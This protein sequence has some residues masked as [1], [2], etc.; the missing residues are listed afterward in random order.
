MGVRRRSD[1]PLHA[2]A[3]YFRLLAEPARLRILLCL[4][5]GELNVMEIVGATGMKQAHVS[6]Q[7]GLLSSEGLLARRKEGTRVYYSLV[8]LRLGDLLDAAESTLREHLRG[9]L[10]E[11]EG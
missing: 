9:R 8:D 7:L 11:L 2:L 1:R 5:G 3:G 4:E 6:R 10:D